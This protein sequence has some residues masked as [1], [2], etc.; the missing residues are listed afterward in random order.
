MIDVL[1]KLLR[2]LTNINSLEVD[3]KLKIE[4]KLAWFKIT[5]FKKYD[6]KNNVVSVLDYKIKFLDYNLFRYLFNEIFLSKE[7]FFESKK[8]DPSI[9][10][11]GSN[12]G[13]SILY[14]KMLYPNAKIMA[15]EPGEETYA[16]IEENIQ[17]NN[18]NSIDIYNVALAKTE[19][20]IDFFYDKSDVGSLMMSAVE[21][22]MP[23]EKRIVKSVCLSSYI[24]HDIDFMKMDIEGAEM[25][26]MED[27]Y[28]NK[29]LQYIQQMVIEYHHHINE[30]VDCF[31]KILQI[32]EDSQFGY[33]IE[34]H[35][36]NN[37]GVEQFQD[38]IIYAYQK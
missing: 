14:F 36:D 15:F 38:I 10:D 23:K 27:L 37:L 6:S 5:F 33:H 21:E 12:I 22:R 32:L 29:K 17:M 11:C 19:G 8:D 9:I 3:E 35:L 16:C 34:G 18:L 2:K 30:G 28:N 26:V 4:L 1:Y 13:M 25:E 31:S 20:T 7:Y 24:N